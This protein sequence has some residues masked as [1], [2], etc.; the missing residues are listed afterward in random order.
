MIA[1]NNISFERKYFKCVHVYIVSN[2]SH[3]QAFVCNAK[4]TY[5]AYEAYL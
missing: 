3:I 2:N 1:K 4:Y 5:E